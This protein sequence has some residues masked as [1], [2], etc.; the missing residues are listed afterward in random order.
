MTIEGARFTAVVLHDRVPHNQAELTLKKGDFVFLSSR[1]T[2]D[3]YAGECRGRK[4]LVPASYVEMVADDE[5][6]QDCVKAVV[7]KSFV[8]RNT[9][10]LSLSRG[11][12]VNITHRVNHAWYLGTMVSGVRG[13]VPAQH[14]EIIS[15]NPSQVVP[16]VDMKK[17][18]DEGKKCDRSDR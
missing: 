18:M 4:G 10:E 2:P 16:V 12:L 8:A 17:L 14:L 6:S 11:N 3:W 9:T 13:L 5:T 15:S 7:I 1:V